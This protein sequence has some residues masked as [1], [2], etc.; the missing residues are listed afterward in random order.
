MGA[1]QEPTIDPVFSPYPCLSFHRRALARRA[2]TIS[3][4]TPEI[5]WVDK[6][7]NRC[8]RRDFFR[9]EARVF[10]SLPVGKEGIPIGVKSSYLLGNRVDKETKLGFVLRSLAMEIRFTRC[11][12]A[13]TC[14]FK[15][16]RIVWQRY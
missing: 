12:A 13:Y 1:Q 9:V 14:S 16:V 6:A 2:L 4:E 8:N 11:Q 7:V 15:K 10:L 5:I 3:V